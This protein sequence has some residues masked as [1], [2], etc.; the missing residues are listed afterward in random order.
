M[1]RDS[2]WRGS[3]WDC[4][5]RRAPLTRNTFP[6]CSFGIVIWDVLTQQ[7]PYSGSRWQWDPQMGSWQGLWEG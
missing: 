6:I 7:K 2:G 3:A 4:A 1:E 5:A